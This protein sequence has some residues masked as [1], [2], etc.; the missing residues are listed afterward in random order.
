MVFSQ[1]A[2][3][4]TS[5]RRNVMVKR[6]LARMHY[7]ESWCVD[8]MVPSQ[9]V[10]YRNG[11]LFLCIAVW[12]LISGQTVAELFLLLDSP[13]CWMRFTLWLHCLIFERKSQCQE[14]FSTKCIFAMLQLTNESGRCRK[15][16]L[17]ISISFC[18]SLNYITLF[19][20][21]FI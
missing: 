16:A 6:T 11:N 17:N 14:P 4:K 15:S 5:K 2:H 19:A 1:W 20:L 7:I 12:M 13:L 21:R 3:I 8:R 9:L 10:A 18:F